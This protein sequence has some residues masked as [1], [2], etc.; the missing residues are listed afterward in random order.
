MDQRR[1]GDQGIAPGPRV[2]NVQTR[3]TASDR[4]IDGE[5]PPV[6]FGQDARL[7][8]RPQHGALCR[9]T[10]LD[11]RHLFAVNSLRKSGNIYDLQAVLGHSSIKTTEIYLDFL[12]PVTRQRAMRR[13]SHLS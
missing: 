13:V 1:R 5:D 2:G 11:L 10:A 4:S 9:V 3:A 12:D 6:E 7:K 8:P